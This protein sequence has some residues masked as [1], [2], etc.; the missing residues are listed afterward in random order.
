M[1][2]RRSKFNFDRG[3]GNACRAADSQVLDVASGLSRYPAG[4]IP[5]QN[6]KVAI[7]GKAFAA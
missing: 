7:R 5:A 4:K 2:A 3:S 6:F 1:T